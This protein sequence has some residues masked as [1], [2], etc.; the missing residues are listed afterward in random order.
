MG[1]YRGSLAASQDSL[2]AAQARSIAALGWAENVH[3]SHL[4]CQPS[5]WGTGQP[6]PALCGTFEALLI[7]HDGVVLGGLRQ[8]EELAPEEETGATD[9]SRGAGR[10]GLERCRA[11]EA[12]GR[13]G[14]EAG[15][16]SAGAGRAA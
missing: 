1:T 6:W 2:P 10:G 13:G 12:G 7:Q 11:P 5:L 3:N 4:R 16:C 8:A 15:T 9:P 14:G